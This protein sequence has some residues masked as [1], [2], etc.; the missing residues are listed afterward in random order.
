MSRFLIAMLVGAT[1]A[2]AAQR[3]RRH[4]TAWPVVPT[5][6]RAPPSASYWKEPSQSQCA[7]AYTAAVG[8]VAKSHGAGRTRFSAESGEVVKSL[9]TR[10]E[11]IA[12][13]FYGRESGQALYLSSDWPLRDR[14]IVGAVL[15]ADHRIAFVA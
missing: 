1:I 8:L 2:A 15:S 14:H 10:K 4:G 12:A 7:G 3:R 5:E 6:Q 9:D 13:A 11:E